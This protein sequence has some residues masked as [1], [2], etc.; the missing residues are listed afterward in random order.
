MIIILY[1]MQTIHTYNTNNHNNSDFNIHIVNTNH[2][3]P[4][5]SLLRAAS[6]ERSNLQGVAKVCTSGRSTN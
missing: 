5:G 4:A 2:I 6:L 1:I 3:S